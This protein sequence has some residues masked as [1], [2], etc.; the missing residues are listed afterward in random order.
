MKKV[1]GF[2]VLIG[3]ISLF[4]DSFLFNK[5]FHEIT[6]AEFQELIKQ[7]GTVA[8]C[9][10]YDKEVRFVHVKHHIACAKSATITEQQRKKTNDTPLRYFVPIEGKL[11][12][13]GLF[14]SHGIH[15]TAHTNWTAKLHRKW[16]S[17][18]CYFFSE[19]YMKRNAAMVEPKDKVK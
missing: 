18:Y 1:T 10:L 8:N 16:R 7:K 15:F 11:Q 14:R 17:L 12:V 5:S 13:I 6:Y 4:V 19:F 9:H 3:L 2:I